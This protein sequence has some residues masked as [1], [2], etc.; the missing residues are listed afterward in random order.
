VPNMPEFPGMENFEGVHHHSS[1]HTSG[2]AFKGK[3]CVV[4]GSNNSAHD[5]C[6]DL[7]E[8]GADVTMVQR[9]STHVSKS[10]TLMELGLGPL[11]SEAAVAAGITTHKA[12]MVVASIPYRLRHEF[13]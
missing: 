1:R 4:I 2:E 12:D 13:E 11:Y 7:W 5:I 8:H 3:K 9:S 6:A 10:D